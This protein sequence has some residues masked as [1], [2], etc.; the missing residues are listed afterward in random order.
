MDAKK[1]TAPAASMF[2]LFASLSE[3]MVLRVW[4]DLR[5]E[6]EASL[7]ILEIWVLVVG[8]LGVGILWIPWEAFMVHQDWM[9]RRRVWLGRRSE[10]SEIERAILVT[11]HVLFL[12]ENSHFSMLSRS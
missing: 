5:G 10:E 7:M 11:G 2:L 3:A 6:R 12:E 1:S 8:G 9:R 4:S